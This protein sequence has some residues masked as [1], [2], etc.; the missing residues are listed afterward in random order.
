MSG[1]GPVT[2]PSPF[3]GAGKT[4]IPIAPLEKPGPPAPIEDM[5]K[6]LDE[7]GVFQFD[8]SAGDANT[9][10][11]S[12]LPE[13]CAEVDL[14]KLFAPFGPIANK[15]VKLMRNESGNCAG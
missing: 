1:K 9:M 8:G 6:T 4:P 15:G 3:K 5:L 7:F 2:V 13:D 11:I 14:Y 12:G 10:Y